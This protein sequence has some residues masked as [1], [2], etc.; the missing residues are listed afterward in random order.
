MLLFVKAFFVQRHGY[1][2]VDWPHNINKLSL[3]LI[4]I[5]IIRHLVTDKNCV[6]NGQRF[7]LQ[8]IVR[9][10]AQFAG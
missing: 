5:N 2:L 9:M 8:F 7:K 10:K 4:E 3:L 1:H 6:I